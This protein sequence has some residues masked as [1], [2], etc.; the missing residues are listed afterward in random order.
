MLIQSIDI[1]YERYNG[2]VIT[3]RRI[4][5]NTGR[6]ASGRGA[7]AIVV[8]ASM[9]TKD[10][11]NNIFSFLKYFTNKYHVHICITLA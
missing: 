4:S 10:N 11:K 9:R 2:R 3:N 8:T 1:R 6:S 5:V 7:N